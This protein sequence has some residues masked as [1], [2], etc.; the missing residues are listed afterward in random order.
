MPAPFRTIRLDAVRP[1]SSGCHR[2]W[3]VSQNLL[4][5]LDEDH[6]LAWLHFFCNNPRNIE[7]VVAIFDTNGRIL[8]SENNDQITSVARGPVGTAL[9]G[10]GRHGVDLVNLELHTQE[11][12]LCPGS[13]TSCLI[14]TPP[15]SLAD[16]DFALCSS[17]HLEE[18][19]SFYRGNPAAR[20]AER[21]FT[22]VTN[23]YDDP[24]DEKPAANLEPSYPPRP[25]W[26]IGPAEVWYFSDRGILTYRNSGGPAGPVTTERWK[27]NDDGC[28]GA[29]SVSEPR[30]FLATCNG[31]HF[32]TDGDF[33]ALFGYTRIALFDVKSRRI[34]ARID[35]PDSA[36]AFLSP[37]GQRIAVA[38]ADKIRLYHVPR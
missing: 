14:F 38:H 19:C 8:S 36:S 30:R 4:I 37:T 35:G 20:V 28:T 26:R 18:S 10:Y 13:P 11:T 29:L 6:L 9:I 27:P 23:G 12:L 33:D 16:S 24:Y 21:T 2:T 3:T 7:S 5:W 31:V 25:S 34:L 17:R 1:E 22:P 32:Y 15:T